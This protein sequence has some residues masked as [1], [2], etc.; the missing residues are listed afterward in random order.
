MQTQTPETVTP[1]TPAT[2]NAVE[3]QATPDVV[4]QP[5]TQ[6][7]PRVDVVDVSDAVLLVADV[8][9]VPGDGVTV[10]VTDGVLTLD[11]LQSAPPAGAPIERKRYSRRFT[12]SETLDAEHIE[13]SLEHGVL[14]LRVPKVPKAQPRRIDV[15]VG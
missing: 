7:V 5:A 11:A 9:G 1:E 2:P 6:V 3:Q 12:L 8:P 13:A 4:E 14:T 15:K 10:E